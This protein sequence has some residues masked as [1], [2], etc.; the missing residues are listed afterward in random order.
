MY[1]EF[2]I[3]LKCSYTIYDVK[4]TFKLKL[5]YTILTSLNLKSLL[6]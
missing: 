3:S 1:T 5:I 2:K 6:Y 4:L